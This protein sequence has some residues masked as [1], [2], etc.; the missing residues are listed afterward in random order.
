MN[1]LKTGALERFDGTWDEWFQVD[2]APE[3]KLSTLGAPAI[4]TMRPWNYQNV[5]AGTCGVWVTH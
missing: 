5:S 4:F 2:D 3:R 1:S